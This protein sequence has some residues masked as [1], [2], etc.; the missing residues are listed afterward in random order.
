MFYICVD[1][2]FAIPQVLPSGKFRHIAVQVL[3]R[4]S[5]VGQPFRSIRPDFNIDPKAALCRWY[6]QLGR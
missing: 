3:P 1:S 6:V 5:V 2:V 4:Q